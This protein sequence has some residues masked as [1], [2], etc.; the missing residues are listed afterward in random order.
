[1][2]WELGCKKFVYQESSLSGTS[3]GADAG[4]FQIKANSTSSWAWAELGNIEYQL[5][6]L[7]GSALK[8]PVGWYALVGLGSYPLLCH[9]Q[10]FLRLS[11]AVT[12]W[13]KELLSTLSGNNFK[14]ITKA[15]WLVL[16]IWT[17]K[18]VRRLDY[19]TCACA[20]ILWQ[21]M[22]SSATLVTTQA[23]VLRRLSSYFRQFQ[24]L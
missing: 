10:L 15:F 20:A 19:E 11:W 5:P 21:L 7:S 16:T 22:I 23:G 4:Y 13:I 3:P 24:M 9:S 6:R 2:C 14:L 18:Y 12:I 8:V 17:Y 1:M